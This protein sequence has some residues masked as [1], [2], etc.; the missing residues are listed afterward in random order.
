MSRQLAFKIR[1]LFIQLPADRCPWCPNAWG[2]QP[3]PLPLPAGGLPRRTHHDVP[4]AA[5]FMGKASAWEEGENEQRARLC[6]AAAPFLAK[7]RLASCRCRAACSRGVRTSWEAKGKWS[8]LAALD[9]RIWHP[10]RGRGRRRP[11]FALT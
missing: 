9:G 4:A 7:R 8:S 3:P 11:V 5:E 1:I 10:G 2:E 6:P